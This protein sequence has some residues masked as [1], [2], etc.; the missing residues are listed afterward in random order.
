MKRFIRTLGG[1]TLVLSL[2]IPMAH[3]AGVGNN[4]GGFDLSWLGWLGLLGLAGLIKRGN[5]GR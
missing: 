1:S 4:D 2:V 3:A 5:N